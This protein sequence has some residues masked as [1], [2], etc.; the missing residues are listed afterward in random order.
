MKEQDLKQFFN[1]SNLMFCVASTE[2]FFTQLNDSWT[3]AL[4]WTEEELKSK[5]FI[6]F[7]HP[8]DI[9]KTA[10]EASRLTTSKGDCVNFI[11]RYITKNGGYKTLSWNSRIIEDSYYCVV[12]DIT[13]EAKRKEAIEKTSETA[14]IGSW[15]VDLME[16]TV[17]WS[18]ETYKIHG[19]T[20]EFPEQNLEDGINFY[21]PKFR[22]MV[23]DCVNTAIQKGTGWNFEA[24]IIT[25]TGKK[26][27][28]QAIGFV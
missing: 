12:Q 13:K 14:K 21:H 3:K 17:T 27:W 15:E 4:G 7:V 23:E 16:S 28:V 24:Q 26:K 18:K 25:V 1:S 9:E 2:G 8:D 22:P 20:E 19:Y 10:A 11:N 6:E 5:P